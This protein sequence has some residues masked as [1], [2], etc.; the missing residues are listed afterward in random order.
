MPVMQVYEK[1]KPFV[2]KT[3]Y[4]MFVKTYPVLFRIYGTN[5][6]K[7]QHCRGTVL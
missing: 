5:Y 3:F 4:K 2:Y 6:W 7:T 1:F